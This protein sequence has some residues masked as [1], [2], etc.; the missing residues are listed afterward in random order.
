MIPLGFFQ[1]LVIP[2]NLILIQ[3][4]I[5]ES[6]A[7]SLISEPRRIHG[8]LAEKHT[9]DHSSGRERR[10]IQCQVGHYLHPNGT[11]CCIKCHKGTYLSEHCSGSDKAPTCSV[12]REGEYMPSQ[13][14]SPKCFACQPCRTNTGFHQIT[15]SNCTKWEN[16]VCGCY[17]NQYKTTRNA[18]FV[19]KNCSDCHNGK[20]RQDCTPDS[21]TICECHRGFFLKE[22][23]NECLPCSSC[24]KEDCKE[25]CETGRVIKSPSNSKELIYVLSF[26]TII[27]AVGFA[28]FIIKAIKKYFPER[29]CFS[30]CTSDQQ[31]KKQLA[32]KTAD[33]TK[34][35]LLDIKEEMILGTMQ[36][37]P[38]SQAQG[39]ELPDC[40]KSARETRISDSPVVLYAVM[41]AVPVLRWKEFMR[42]LGLSENTI[43]RIFFDHRH[44]RDA[45]Y[46]TLKEWRLLANH[47]ATME[48]IS[49]VLSKM[50]LSGCIEEIQEALAKQ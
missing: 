39:Q 29:Q 47:D 10:D 34:N 38:L 20:I 32:S 9:F 13:N 27:F 30:S 22:D 7:I 26:L 11:H 37:L 40:I 28:V 36:V 31:L 48:R 5:G 35:S 16:T 17:S 2:V 45:Q 6:L 15:K 41:D 49:Q 44:A 12:C 46:E 3:W 8:V 14:S 24:D 33:K 21:D 25:H 4:R 42:Y 43:D 19:C 1:V 50:D 18:E 23:Q